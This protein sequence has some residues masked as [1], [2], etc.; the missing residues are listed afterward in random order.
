M[1]TTAAGGCGA[2]TGGTATVDALV[3]TSGGGCEAWTG[4][5]AAVGSLVA[6]SCGESVVLGAT[7][8]GVGCWDAGVDGWDAGAGAIAPVDFG[9]EEQAKPMTTIAATMS[10]NNGGAFNIFVYESA[11]ETVR[12]E[13]DGGLVSRAGIPT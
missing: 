1:G 9:A 8:V 4:A 12:P 10:Q 13:A 2:G 3:A 11:S 6:M 5:T 7:C